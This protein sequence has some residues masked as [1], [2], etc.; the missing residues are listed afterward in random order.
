MIIFLTGASGFIGR[1]LAERLAR[2]GHRV[3]CLVRPSSPVEHLKEMGV[4]LVVGDV[5]DS[6]ALREGMRGCDWLFHLANLYEMWL[7]EPGLFQAVNV[8]GTRMV[9][10]AA[11]QSGVG[12]VVYVSTAAVYGKPEEVPFREEA[13]HGK[14]LFSAYART[15]AEGE[16]IAWEFCARGMAISVL[17]PGIVLGKGDDKASG[18]YIAGILGR[19]VPSTIFNG[20]RAV[21]VHVADVVDAVCAAAVRPEAAGQGYLVGGHCLDGREYAELIAELGRVQLPIFRFPDAVVILAA[22]LLTGLSNVTRRPPWWGLSVDAARTLHEGF[23]FDGSKAERELGIR[24]R[25]IRQALEEAISSYRVS[26]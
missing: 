11:R 2:E 18:K 15:K 21:Y 1:H 23:V 4:E 12:R 8:E 19:R 17:Y 24:Y 9:F 6:E 7:P 3:R 22:H 25:P 26:G 14:E 13:T 16:R 5:Q 20:S 10:E